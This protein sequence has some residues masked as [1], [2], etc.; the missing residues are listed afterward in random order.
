MR[1][2]YRAYLAS[3]RNIPQ[4]LES[5][6][7]IATYMD[8]ESWSRVADI[9]SGIGIAPS[10]VRY[11]LKNMETDGYVEQDQASRAWRL[12]ML[13]QADLVGFNFLERLHIWAKQV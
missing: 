4:G 11:H 2:D 6:H 13:N 5:R 3:I 7:K 1:Y 8:A 10:T 9:S 12:I